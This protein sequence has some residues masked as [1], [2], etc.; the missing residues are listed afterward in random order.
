MGLWAL[1][2]LLG[3]TEFTSGETPTTGTPETTTGQGSDEGSSTGD[4]ST[5][6]DAAS[7]GGSTTKESSSDSDGTTTGPDDPPEGDGSSSTGEGA[8]DE[9][10]SGGIEAFPYAGDYD[11]TLSAECQ[12]S[13]QGTLEVTV[14][15]VGTAVGSATVMGQSTSLVGTVSETGQVSIDVTVA[16]FTC[17]IGGDLADDGSGG[18]GSFTC[19]DV[20]CSGI[21]SVNPA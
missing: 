14:T 4:T 3:C 15:E 5:G 1:G 20:G 18:S 13:V 2:A 10:S 7:G 12:I 11:G 9:G 17:S 8:E 19:P 21:W 6:V 16:G